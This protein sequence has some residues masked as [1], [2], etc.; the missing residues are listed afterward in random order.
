METTAGRFLTQ[1]REDLT[2]LLINKIE[3]AGGNTRDY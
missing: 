2:E 3:V 1:S